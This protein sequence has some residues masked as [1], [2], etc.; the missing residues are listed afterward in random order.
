MSRHPTRLS[1]WPLRLRLIAGFSAATMIALL[2]AGAFVYWRVEYALDRGLD[3]EL[4]EATESLLPLI[5]NRGTVSRSSAAEATGVAWQ[6]LDGEGQVRDRGG[7]APST[8]MVGRGP[9][10]H[11]TGASRTYNLGEILPI[12]PRPYRVRISSA[13]GDQRFHLLVAVRR[14]HRDEALRELLVQLTSAGLA[15]LAFTAFVGDR[16]ARA[17]LRPVERYRSRAAEIAE[18]AANLRLDVPPGRD[19]EVT[20]LG[21]TFNEMLASLERALDRERAFVNE[22]SHELRTPV[23][24]LISRVQFARRKVRSQAEYEQI[25]EDLDIDLGRLA[26][27]TEHLLQV[28]S[29]G[30]RQLHQPGDLVGV[31]RRVLAQRNSIAPT[32]SIAADLPDDKVFISLADLDV[33]RILTN[34]IDNAEVHGAPP[35]LMSIDQPAKGWARIVVSDAGAGMPPDLL[36]TATR[37]FARAEDAR[38]RP[39]AGLGLAV[40][41]SLVTGAGGALRLCHGGHHSTHGREVAIECDHGAGMTV[42]ALLPL[43]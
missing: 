14:D 11:V 32:S 7:P 22:A 13:P 27:L 5:G 41:E 24:L 35:A 3:T 19:D 20:R 23:T 42:T 9:L 1:R 8:A 25:L 18:G 15:M 43:A 12:S 33:E 29:A 10:A 34:L 31:A 2:A 17:A 37:R 28:G 26:E 39:G 4:H 16:L 38:S 36:D 21:H 30:E 6:V 40:V